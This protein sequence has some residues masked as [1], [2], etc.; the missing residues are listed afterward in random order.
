MIEF[1]AAWTPLDHDYPAARRH[2]ARLLAGRKTC[3][4]FRPA[5]GR[6]GVPKSSL[7]GLRESVLKDP[8]AEPWPAGAR[9][10]LRVREGEQLDA[11][12]LVKRTAEGHRPC[13]SVARVAADPW[14]RGLLAA[15]GEGVLEPVSSACRAL[16][17]EV[18]HRLDTSA[19]R[20]HPH[21]ATFPYE[22][23]AVFRSRHHELWEESRREGES[24]EDSRRKF[25][26]L[27]DAL[28]ELESRAAAANMLRAPILTWPSWRLTATGWARPCRS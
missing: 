13:P 2:V 19:Q 27:E 14:L 26:P 7:D 9:R 1:Y 3:R 4:D 22:G 25:R 21:Y 5:K 11:I 12:G 16:G 24:L 20:G 23:T 28:A 15:H 17:D 10:R 6:A 8:K 18:L